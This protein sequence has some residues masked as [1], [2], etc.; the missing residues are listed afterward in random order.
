VAVLD[1]S[2]VRV[3]DTD[4]PGRLANSY[5]GNPDVT[6]PKWWQAVPRTHRESPA[7]W[8]RY[9]PR[10]LADAC[11]AAARYSGGSGV[12]MGVD[13]AHDPL[14]ITATDT[15]DDRK[16]RPTT[17]RFYALVMPMRV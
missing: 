1:K 5:P 12:E 16:L 13:R 10:Y 2:N 14:V 9:N 4:S 17:Q 11:E 15:C 3:H 7:A 6:F 8:S